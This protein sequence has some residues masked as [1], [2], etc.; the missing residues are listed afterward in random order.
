MIDIRCDGRLNYACSGHVYHGLQ[1]LLEMKSINFNNWCWGVS[2]ID[3]FYFAGF[4]IERLCEQ[5]FLE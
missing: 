1:W 4:E 2:Y 3:C 5:C